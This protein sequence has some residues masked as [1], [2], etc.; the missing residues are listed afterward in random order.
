MCFGARGC[1]PPIP[2]SGRDECLHFSS[3]RGHNGAKL[4]IRRLLAICYGNGKGQRAF[5]EAE[6]AIAS[7]LGMPSASVWEAAARILGPGWHPRSSGACEGALNRVPAFLLSFVQSR[8]KSLLENN[9][10]RL[11]SL[12]SVDY[13]QACFIALANL[14]SGSV[15]RT[16]SQVSHARRAC[17]TPKRIFA[18]CEVWCESVLMTIF[19]PCRFACRR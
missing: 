19:T 10:E 5:F 17:R 2:H 6:S 15:F 8:H 11:F 13:D 4:L 9:L 12:R 3:P 1:P 14:D 18:R 7:L 16:S